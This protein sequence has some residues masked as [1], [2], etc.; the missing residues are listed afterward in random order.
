MSNRRDDIFDTLSE[1]KRLVGDLEIPTGEEFSLQSILAEFGQGAAEPAPKEEPAPACEEPVEE[2]SVP[3]E[4]PVE[5]VSVEEP[6]A[7]EEP[8]DE[9]SAE[10]SSAEEEPEEEPVPLQRR[11]KILQFPGIFRREE[12]EESAAAEE[13]AVQESVPSEEVRDPAEEAISEE[14][15]ISIEAVMSRTVNAVLEE[16]DALLDEREPLR[17]RIG[18]LWANVKE[19]AAGLAAYLHPT[20]KRETGRRETPLPPEPDMEQAVRESR[21]HCK[22]LRKQLLL[23]LLPVLPLLAM[24]VIHT[25]WPRILPELWHETA[26]LRCGVLGGLLLVACLL[27]PALWR[28]MV[29]DLKNRRV[30]CELGAALSALVALG[31]CIYGAAVNQTVYLPLAAPAALLV[32]LCLLGRLL[33]A[34][35][36]LDGFRLADVGGR[37]PFAVAVSAAGACKQQGRIEGFYHSFGYPDPARRSQM[38]LLP[39]L[40]ATATVLA[41]VVCI[42]GER[43][44]EFLWVWSAMLTASLPLGLPLCGTLSLRCLNRRLNRSG[45]AVAGYA[46][47]RAVSASRRMVVTD[48]D[49]FPPG[50]VSLNGLKIYGEEIGKVVSYAAT[51]ARAAESQLQPIFEQMLASEGGIHCPYE[52]LHFYEDGGVGITI[53]GESVTMGSEFFMKKHRVTLP[54]ELKVKTGVFL[55]VDGQLIAIFAIKYQASRNVEWALRALRRSRIEPVLAVRSGNIT[56]GLLK[57]RFGV[58]VKPV[59][60]DVSTRLALSDLSKEQAESADAIIYREGLMPF[61]ET[62]IG[63]RRCCQMVRW[64][65]ALCWLGSLCGLLLAYYLTGVAAYSALGAGY[66]LVFLLLWLLP[67]V[68]LGDMTRRY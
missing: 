37:P 35:A 22:R 2:I 4:E 29:A 15:R 18:F 38:V 62:V 8:S 63:S 20:E 10:A 28:L 26:L 66:V 7:E 16:D 43:M 52:D 39:L 13:E 54:R 27:C 60:P 5:E 44:Q 45:C 1:T 30:G 9:Q 68:L 55:A 53:Q 32:W 41:G 48:N 23:M 40:L 56:P 57:R 65:T 19:K 42:G 58:D 24:T 6:L 12:P 67:T 59:Y 46:G 11:A 14:Q 61:A 51:V 50:T 31:D 25:W 21:R 64:S 33:A 3:A 34:Q 36:R 49:V 17:D 47:A